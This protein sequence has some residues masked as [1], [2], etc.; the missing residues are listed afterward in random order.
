MQLVAQNHAGWLYTAT[1]T[2]CPG[3]G[4]QEAGKVRA[5]R[6]RMETDQ[7]AGRPSRLGRVQE[8]MQGLSEGDRA[9]GTWADRKA[10][11]PT[12][13]FVQQA[14]AQ[15]SGDAPNPGRL[16]GSAGAVTSMMGL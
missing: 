14:V 16:G 2:E 4:E 7:A 6:T 1:W 11:L 13:A 15:M 12:W 10:R 9:G 8:A 5:L 3:T